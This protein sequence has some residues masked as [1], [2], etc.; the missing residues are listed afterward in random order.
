MDVEKALKHEKERCE[1]AEHLNRKQ[2]HP[3][4]DPLDK[5]KE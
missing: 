5:W 4:T 1:H 3:V 2:V